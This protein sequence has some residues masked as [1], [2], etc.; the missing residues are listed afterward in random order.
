MCSTNSDAA[1]AND[2]FRQTGI[3]GEVFVTDR[4]RQLGE[5]CLFGVFEAIKGYRFD[6]NDDA[7]HDTGVVAISGTSVRWT[8]S[9]PSRAPQLR[10][11]LVSAEGELS[12]MYGSPR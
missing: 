4:V 6:L 12:P 10:I 11:L 7:A 1:T 9:S 5:D 3:G 2:L 8:I